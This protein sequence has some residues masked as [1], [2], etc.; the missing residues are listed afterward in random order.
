MKNN[1]RKG[2][3]RHIDNRKQIVDSSQERRRKI[4][5]QWVRLTWYT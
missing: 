3:N 2:E 4:K 1:K 5:I